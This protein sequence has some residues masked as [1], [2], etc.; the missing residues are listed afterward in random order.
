MPENQKTED[1]DSGVVPAQQGKAAQ[2]KKWPRRLGITLGLLAGLLILLVFGLPLALSLRPAPKTVRLIQTIALPGHAAAVF[3]DYLTLSGRTLYL[4]GTSQNALIAVDT[5]A[6]TVI[7]TVGGLAGIHGFAAAPEAHLGF[8]SDGAEDKVGVIDLRTN[9]LL[10]KIPGG[11]N[12]DAIIYD[13]KDNLI[14]AADHAGKAATLIDPATRKVVGTVALGGVAEFAQ[15]DPVTGLVYQNLEDTSETVVVDP[16]RQAVV[17]RWK[18]APGEGPTGLTLDTANHRIFVVCGN[19]TLVVLDERDGHFIA[20]LPIGSVVDGVGYDPGLKRLYTANALATMTVIQQ[21][22]PDA[23]HVLENAP[24]PFGGHTLAV[25][26]ETHRVYVASPG[27]GT[28]HISVY[29]ARP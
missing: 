15:A 12:P 18:T 2:K 24:T 7:G 29:E 21:D 20:S 25:D 16:K 14:Y 11:V 13:A 17:A 10:G 26:T 28:G 9:T 5:K 4:G 1:R 3:G 27:F 19:K 8:A 23:Y 6:N 22:T